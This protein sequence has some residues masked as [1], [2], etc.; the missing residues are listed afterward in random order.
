MQFPF[1]HKHILLQAILLFSL[2]TAAQEQTG[3]WDTYVTTLNGKTPVS[4]VVNLALSTKSA[5]RSRPYVI[6]LRTKVHYPDAVGQP[7]QEEMQELDS[8]ETHLEAGLSGHSGAVYVGRFTQRSLREFYFYALDTLDY[9]HPVREAMMQHPGYDWLCQAKYD[10][11]WTNYFQVLY[12]SPR[13]LERIQDRR[14]VDVLKKKGDHLQD[15]RPIDH[16]FSFKTK[17]AREAFLRDPFL[18]GFQILEMP[19]DPGNGDFPYS[20]HLNRKDVPDYRFIDKTL[21]PLWETARKNS[22]K[23]EGWET[24]AM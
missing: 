3:D 12:P 9:I 16:Y 8:M 13:D 21:L 24:N 6:I 17:A 18:T 15:A 19:A 22:G 5:Q 7:G 14:L 1:S 23:Y 2:R 20:L 4:V 11:D 10:R